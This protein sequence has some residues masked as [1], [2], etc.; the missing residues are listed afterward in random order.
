RSRNIPCFR[1]SSPR[2]SSR[3]SR[4]LRARASVGAR[5]RSIAQALPPHAPD[6]ARAAR[7]RL[8]QVVSPIPPLALAHAD[9]VPQESL[10]HVGEES[11]R[12]SSR[13]ITDVLVEVFEVL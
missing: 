1:S 13:G 7:I 2:S 11:V 6:L 10:V 12:R 4:V 5:R 9:P 8:D 3:Q